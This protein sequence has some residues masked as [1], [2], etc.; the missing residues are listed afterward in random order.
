MRQEDIN[1]IE[2]NMLLFTTSRRYAPGELET[3]F[4]IYN[5]ITGES[6]KVTGC[7]RCVNTT[8]QIILKHY[9]QARRKD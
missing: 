3:I 1:Y 9:D 5:R 7:G 4:S 8:K 2:S 6:K